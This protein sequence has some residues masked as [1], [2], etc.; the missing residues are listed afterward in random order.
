LCEHAEVQRS[1]LVGLLALA[2]IAFAAG[3]GGG[4]SP[5]PPTTPAPPQ[6]AVLDWME[7]YEQEGEAVEFGVR[8]FAVTED[9]WRAEISIT[10]DTS[11]RYAVGGSETEIDR[12]F[13][14]MLFRTGE[15]QELEQRNQAEDLPGLRPAQEFDPELPLVLKPGATWSGTMSAEGSLAAGLFARMVF[16]PL[17][18][19]DD[20]PSGFPPRLVWITDNSYQ[21]KGD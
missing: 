6:V 18:P 17:V 20:S 3:C 8:R 1:L 11:T 2:A 15:L 14:V 12:A 16:G 19:V 5:L 21:L 7:R 13:G 9:G 4:D 10:N